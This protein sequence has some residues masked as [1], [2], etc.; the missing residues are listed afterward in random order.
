M[1]GALKKIVPPSSATLCG[2]FL[3]VSAVP[4]YLENSPIGW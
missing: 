4:F 3:P 1:L 2:G